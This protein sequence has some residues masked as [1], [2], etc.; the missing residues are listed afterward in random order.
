MS[1]HPDDDVCLVPLARVR[2]DGGT[3]TRANG[4]EKSTVE[5]FASVY[6]STPQSMPPID[7]VFDGKDYWVYDGFHRLGAASAAGLK[8]IPVRLVAGTLDRARLLAGGANKDHDA[9]RR[10]NKDKRRAVE[11]VFTS[12]ESRGMSDRAIAQHCRV[13]H[14]LVGDVRKALSA[15]AH[16]EESYRYRSAERGGQTYP[17][18]VSNIGKGKPTPPADPDDV[19]FDPPAEGE[20]E[21]GYD[22][23]EL[24]PEEAQEAAENLIR[25]AREGT[26]PDNLAETAEA[27]GRA[28]SNGKPKAAKAKQEEGY[29]A[30]GNL[31]PP[32]LRDVFADLKLMEQIARIRRWRE[33]VEHHAAA[34]AVASVAPFH[35]PWLKALQIQEYLEEAHA[36]LVAAEE[37]IAAALPHALCPHCIETAG[38]CDHCRGMGWVPR[39]RLEELTEQ[40]RLGGA[41]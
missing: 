21:Q 10:T 40:A 2:T 41:P 11:I 34:R 24:T 5:D 13:S 35:G 25:M 23:P 36:N 32:T 22:P 31:L 33:T 3:Q 9:A 8:E 27:L 15:G 12:Q 26:L 14:V 30:L 7:C 28:K 17:M 6:R 37:L 19:P 1:E 18:D 29:D 39:W 38:G 4:T 20:R 16:L